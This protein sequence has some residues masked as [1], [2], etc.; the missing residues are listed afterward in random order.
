ML[1]NLGLYWF[2]F[3]WY[4]DGFDVFALVRIV[5]WHDSSLG[6]QAQQQ[7]DTLASDFVVDLTI[8][9]DT[10]TSFISLPFFCCTLT[11]V[12]FPISKSCCLCCFVLGFVHDFIFSFKLENLCCSMSCS[13]D[14][15][16]VLRGKLGKL[17]ERIS[18]AVVVVVAEV[19]VEVEVV[20]S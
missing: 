11:L 17:P 10:V 7:R 2:R 5:H 3:H 13:S 6:R 8:C 16:A 1:I 18:H 14:Q 20:S 15:P 12:F 4:L 19:A 9:R